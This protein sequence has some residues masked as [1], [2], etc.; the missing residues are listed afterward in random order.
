MGESSFILILMA[1]LAAIGLILLAWYLFSRVGQ[2]AFNVSSPSPCAYR[3]DVSQDWID[4]TVQYDG[5][6][7]VHRQ[8]P[9]GTVHRWERNYLD[10]GVA[11][12]LD[13]RGVSQRWSGVEQALG[14]PCCYQGVS[15][16]LLLSP[17]RYT[18]LRSWVEASPPG[19]NS[20]VA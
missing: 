19:W 3:S 1:A 9:S 8:T 4:G 18:A 15:F 13:P 6:M 12:R 5:T 2:S 11:E 7:L 17:A 10:L 20:N 14:V 16:H